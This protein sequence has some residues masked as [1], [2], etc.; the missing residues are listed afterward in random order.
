[1]SLF[2]LLCLLEQLDLLVLFLDYLFDFT[3]LNEILLLD[4]GHH[5]VHLIQVLL[6]HLCDL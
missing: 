2:L 6:I 3:L 4:D 1:M 5:A